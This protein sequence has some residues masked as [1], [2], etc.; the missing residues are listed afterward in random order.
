[1]ANKTGDSH[2]DYLMEKNSQEIQ[3]LEKLAQEKAAENETLIKRIH[4]SRC[5]RVGKENS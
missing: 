4:E 1:M 2:T 3:R 5:K